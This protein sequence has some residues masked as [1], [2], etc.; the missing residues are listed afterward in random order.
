MHARD[1]LSLHILRYPKRNLSSDDDQR[2][3]QPQNHQPADFADGMH[4]LQAVALSYFR[5][6]FVRPVLE[7]F[8]QSA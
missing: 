6:P 7:H 5:L 2:A 1:T 8:F 4:D 3:M